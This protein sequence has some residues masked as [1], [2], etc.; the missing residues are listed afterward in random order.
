MPVL[1]SDEIERRRPRS[2]TLREVPIGSMDR[3]QLGAYRCPVGV[4]S[5]RIASRSRSPQPRARRSRHDHCCARVHDHPAAPDHRRRLPSQAR[6]AGRRDLREHLGFDDATA[7]ILDKSLP[8][9]AQE[10]RATGVVGVLFLVIAAT[11]FARALER[12]LLAIWHTPTA[13]IRF[14]W[15]WLASIA[16]VVIGIAL[17]VMTRV[18]VHGDG[19]IPVIEFITEVVIWTALWWI[20]SWIVIKSM[21]QPSRAPARRGARRGPV[22]RSRT[23]RSSRPAPILAEA[24]TRFGVLGM[25]FS[26]IGW[27][28]LLSCVLLVAATAGRVVYLTYIGR[29]W[30]RSVATPA[31][32]PYRQRG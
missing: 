14:A 17:I 27:L 2:T 11:S 12:G 19:A 3:E 20:A 30:Q 26:Y 4:W 13:S 23:G 25:A 32:W 15:R 18:V 1:A 5:V 9:G 28:F 24:A 31:P 7:E 16:A 6:P 10:L 21:R 8:A 22:R 29:A